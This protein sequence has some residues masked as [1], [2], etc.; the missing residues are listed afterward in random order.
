MFQRAMSFRP[1]AETHAVDVSSRV[2]D[3][4]LTL[5]LYVG[6][7]DTGVPPKKILVIVSPD[8]NME[9]ILANNLSIIS[10]IVPHLFDESVG[11]GGLGTCRVYTHDNR[12]V[13]VKSPVKTAGF[14]DMSVVKGIVPLT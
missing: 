7:F 2:Q 14:H 5:E 4:T 6:G 11:G 3:M 12:V 8:D 13:G 1:F 10:N 9:T